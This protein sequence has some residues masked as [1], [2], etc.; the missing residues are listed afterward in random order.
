MLRQSGLTIVQL[1]VVLLI[2]GA[3]GKF[4]VEFII[5]RRCD[6]AAASALC[7]HSTSPDSHNRPVSHT[8]P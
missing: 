3:V 7:S 5:A 1:M 8:P 4:A 2:A 6:N